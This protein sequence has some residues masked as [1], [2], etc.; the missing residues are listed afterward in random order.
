MSRSVSSSPVQSP[1]SRRELSWT[2]CEREVRKLHT[3][4]SEDLDRPQSRRLYALELSASRHAGKSPHHLLEQAKRV[5][6]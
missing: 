6:R 3:D 1:S 5:L 2:G 4:A